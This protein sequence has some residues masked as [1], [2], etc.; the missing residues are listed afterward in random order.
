VNSAVVPITTQNLSGVVSPQVGHLRTLSSTGAC[1]A[2]AE[3]SE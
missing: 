2:L 1:R 3:S